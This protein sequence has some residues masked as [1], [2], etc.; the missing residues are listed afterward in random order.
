M[1]KAFPRMIM[2]EMVLSQNQQEET[3]QKIPCH[4]IWCQ[5]I[6]HQNEF[7]RNDIWDINYLLVEL[8]QENKLWPSYTHGK[9]V[10]VKFIWKCN[11]PKFQPN[12]NQINN[13]K[14]HNEK[15]LVTSK[16]NVLTELWSLVIK[17]TEESKLLYHK[18]NYTM[19]GNA[20]HH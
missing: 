2:T 1:P 9:W 14:I 19:I 18:R 4:D 5:N 7:L 6:L 10:W 20:N 12:E 16:W 15:N 11:I 17:Y 3:H 13:N 8:R